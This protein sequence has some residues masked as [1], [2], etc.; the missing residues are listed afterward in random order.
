MNLGKKPE[1]MTEQPTYNIYPSDIWYL[2]SEYISPE[3]VG[4]FALISRQT[5]A[6]TTTMKF[7][8]NLYK[9]Y[10]CANVALP[11]RLQPDCMARPGGIRACA[12]RSLFYTYQLFV[13]RLVKQSQQDFHLLVKRYVDRIW[14][15]Q[16]NNT[17]WIYFYKLKRKLLD[18]S[19]LAESESLHR[20][21]SKSLKSMRD[22]Y[23]NTEEGCVLL[24][25]SETKRTNLKKKKN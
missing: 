25:V 20:R 21:N 11:I 7:W 2:I 17:K 8:K 23:L 4:R 22:I 12:I 13:Q 1:V 15:S 14:F 9:R 19:R 3:D 6:I 16:I 24:V 10:L 18:G 5:Y